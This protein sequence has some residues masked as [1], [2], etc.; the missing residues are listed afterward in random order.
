MT[1][2]DEMLAAVKRDPAGAP[3]EPRQRALVDY[4]LK[5]TRS[6]DG[7]TENDIAAL[8]EKGLTDA[9]IHD[10][11]AVAAYYN[12]VNR[13]ALGLGVEIEDEYKEKL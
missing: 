7:I 8:R 4:A 6:P 9:G 1:E 2:D 5:L 11:A 13:M 3:L 10:A 12:F